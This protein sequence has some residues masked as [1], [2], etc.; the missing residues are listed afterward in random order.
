MLPI[1]WYCFLQVLSSQREKFKELMA[2]NSS[3]LVSESAEGIVKKET[4]KEISM[5]LLESQ[6]A[7]R[8]SQGNE[9]SSGG[10][11]CGRHYT[12]SYHCPIGRITDEM[13]V[14]YGSMGSLLRCGWRQTYFASQLKK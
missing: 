7:L 6:R 4:L 1:Y 10:N 12:L 8:D 14:D 9:V 13:E 5:Q 11:H 3:L 2:L